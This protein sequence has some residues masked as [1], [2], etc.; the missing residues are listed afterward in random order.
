MTIFFVQIGN[1]QEEESTLGTEVV[2]VVKPYTP[3]ISDAFK[4]KAAPKLNDS[5]TTTKKKVTYSIFSVPVAST[6]TPAKGKAAVV[7]KSQKSTLYDNYATLGF[8]SYTSILAELYSN[9]QI[10]RTEDFGVFVNHNSSQ[11][12][13]EGTIVEDFFYD[14]RLN[15]NYGAREIDYNWRADLDAKHQVYNWYG[16]PENLESITSGMNEPLFNKDFD[17]SHSY[18]TGAINGSI[19]FKESFFKGAKATFRYFGDDEE[20]TE[21]RAFVKPT[22]ELP[23]AGELITTTITADYIN[24]SFADSYGPPEQ[25][26]NYSFI[27]AGINPSLTILRDDLEVN[28]GVAAFVSLDTENSDT[29]IYFYPKITAS[30]QVVGD[31]FIAYAGLEGDLKQNNYHDFAQENPF[32]SPT[33]LIQPTDTQYDGYIGMKGKLSEAMSYNLR[34]SYTSESNKAFIRHNA[35]SQSGNGFGLNGYSNGNSFNVV[36]D[37]TKT[38]SGFAELN[39]DVNAN[40]K[41]KING[42]Y[43]TYTLDTEEEAWN[44]PELQASLFADYQITEQWFAGVNLFYTGERKDLIYSED[45]ADILIPQSIAT[46]DAYFDA[47]AHV[48]Y[49]FNDK[50]SVFG[51]V[52]NILNTNYEKWLNY[53][54]Q[55]IQGLAGATYKFDF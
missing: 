21:L 45:P 3:T 16:I 32:I 55:G 19:N 17:V 10:S 37:D 23:I 18:L 7:K 35:Y 22:L 5:V 52:N 53:N 14:S 41:L 33:L 11:G 48:G 38:I 12:G 25:E 54:V 6:F 13:I 49:R 30:Y 51:R 24:G 29:D 44:L 20:S 8:G 4:V 39:F 27:N 40:F 50:L 2:N 26:I 31:T 42:Q 15:L 36:Y 47:N 9:F 34:G 43:N 28:L 46:L 1:A